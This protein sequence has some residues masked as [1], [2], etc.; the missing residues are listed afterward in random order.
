MKK[1][2]SLIALAVGLTGFTAFAGDDVW[3]LAY[4]RQRYEGRVEY[5]ANGKPYQVP[6]PNP[7]KVEQL[8]LAV[9][10]D[11][12]H[13]KPLHDNQPVWSQRL[14]DP[15]IHRGND[16]LF[17]LLATGGGSARNGK[18]RKQAGP[19][20]LH[21]TSKDLKHW[22]SVEALPLMKG[23]SDDDGRPSRNIWA[24]EWFF[25]EEKGDY[26]LVWSSSFEDA[27]WK[28][29][30]LWFCR[31]KD[32]KEF[33]PAKVLF[34]P[35][36]SVIDGTLM[37]HDGRYY[38]FHKEEEF[39]PATGERR[40]IRLAVSDQLE[41]PYEIQDGEMNGG[42]LVPTITEG[43]S[44]M[45]D[46]TKPGWLLLYDYCM[47]DRYGLS[48]SPDLKKWTIEEDV[49][50]PPDARHSSVFK[51]SREEFEKLEE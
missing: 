34:S 21:A 42:Q 36:Y 11:G 45:P 6:L 17:H 40:A 19:V 49:S 31:T 10:E 7:M 30:Q 2:A 50:F 26:L 13:W 46:P 23:V 51:L 44:V 9:S 35:G 4:F 22:E 43:P 29:S 28:K 20:C 25:D 3:M 14:R 15:F 27:G 18:D 8:H 24:P 32:W 12:R 39:S 5:D 1:L 41:G 38:L 33:T 16:G 47:T 37:K 48:S